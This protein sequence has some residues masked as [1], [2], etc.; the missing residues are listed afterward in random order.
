MTYIA[1]TNPFQH[2]TDAN[3]RIWTK[4][5]HDAVIAAGLVQTSDTG[6]ID[7]ATVNKPSTNSMA[8]PAMYRFNDTLQA[9]APIFVQL[10]F[11]TG[12]TNA[13]WPGMVVGVGTATNGTNLLTGRTWSAGTMKYG[14]TPTIPCDLRVASGLDKSYLAL[15]WAINQS[16]T[17]GG[18]GF[19]I[20]RS[21]NADGSPNADGFYIFV[22]LGSGAVST[23]SSSASIS[24][25]GAGVQSIGGPVCAVGGFATGVQATE[26]SMFPH[27]C[28]TPKMQAPA[29][30]LLGYFAA[31]IPYGGTVTVNHYGAA[32]YFCMGN[33]VR[34][35]GNR[36]IPVSTVSLAFRAE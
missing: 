12:D 7:F 19:V 4:A 26:V 16:T 10:T 17:Q 24:N 20:D 25:A 14:G 21:R 18:G 3:F 29:K 36:D 13:T 5:V 1:T 22:Y 33:R 30:A 28:C 8:I 2:D 6:Q 34:A 9:T 23:L 15:F 31:D 35:A 27:F 32:P 11:G